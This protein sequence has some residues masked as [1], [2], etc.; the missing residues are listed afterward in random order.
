[1][2]GPVLETRGIEQ[3]LNLARPLRRRLQESLEELE[4][5]RHS[6]GWDRE[7]SRFTDGL[8]HRIQ[9]MLRDLVKV[10]SHGAEFESCP[11]GGIRRAFHSHFSQQARQDK[12]GRSV[13]PRHLRCGATFAPESGV[14]PR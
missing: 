14:R 1:M 3:Q 12:P 10:A 9:R 4:T 5:V 2:G 11:I 7:T 8:E 6:Q 13:P